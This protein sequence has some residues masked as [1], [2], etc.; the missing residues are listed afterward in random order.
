MSGYMIRVANARKRLS[1]NQIN[2]GTQTD[3]ANITIKV[4]YERKP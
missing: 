4:D 1:N 2:R 3:I